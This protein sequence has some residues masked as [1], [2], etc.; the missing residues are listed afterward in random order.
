MR[1]NTR[2]V[3]AAAAALLAVAPVV[4]G[5]A[6]VNNSVSAE[7][8]SA[9][10]T[11]K[12][13]PKITLT[14]PNDKPAE[15]TPYFVQTNGDK[16]T[17]VKTGDISLGANSVNEIINQ[18]KKANYQVK[19][20]G[21]NVTVSQLSD[22]EIM[23]AVY[24]GLSQAGIT[25]NS[26]GTFSQPANTFTVSLSVTA[27]NKQVAT[28][29]IT[30]KPFNVSTDYSANPVITY[31]GKTYNHNQA[32]EADFGYVPVNGTVDTAAIQ[33][34]FSAVA[35]SSDKTALSV[36][37]D[38]SKVNPAVAGSYPVTVTATNANQKSTV[39]TFNL[40]VGIKGAK[41]QVANSTDGKAIVIYSINGNTVSAT[42]AT[43]NNGT[44]VP[45]FGTVEVNGTSYTRI[46]GENTNQFVLTSVFN[47][48]EKSESHV[49]M[50]DSRAYDKDGNYLG[51]M[52]YAYDNIDIVPTVVTIKGKTYYKVAN[53]DEYVR[54][55]NIT[56]N[57]RTLK[58]NAYIYW[59]SYRRTPG[60]G[61]M[62]RGQTVT[63]YGGQMRFKNG[64]KYYRIEGCRN[65][66][67]RYIK[68]VNFY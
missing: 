33:K 39:L 53:K 44:S 41:Y 14:N 29:P 27:S 45:T 35:S 15:G 31:N 36:A 65:N 26:N 24:T 59:S 16:E 48:V 60:T 21:Q 1:K 11:T 62:Y 38:T 67:K 34:A 47:K 68:A 46:N 7:V 58:H 50:V 54:V 57:Q 23:S 6:P 20:D 32:I 66:N 3:T 13:A 63:T 37:V 43:I 64:K 5:V 22:S 12:T 2:I 10:S 42:S 25:V 18:I 8:K 49:V 55:T 28:L 51:H 30:V 52:Y 56:G 17:I 61:K 19:V 40:N 9:K 4:S